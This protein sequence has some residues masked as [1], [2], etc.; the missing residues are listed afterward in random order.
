[1]NHFLSSET[2]PKS[3]FLYKPM[4]CKT[5]TTVSTFSSAVA[6]ML[7]L[8]ETSVTILYFLLFCFA[9][10]QGGLLFKGGFYFFNWINK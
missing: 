1:M 9:S 8:M 2:A 5:V 7:F 6:N 10:K 3:G 4:L